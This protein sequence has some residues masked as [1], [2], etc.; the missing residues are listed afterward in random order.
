MYTTR[1][2]ARPGLR[3]HRFNHFITR[4]GN[5]D[6]VFGVE[7][8]LGQIYHA[9]LAVVVGAEIEAL[10]LQIVDAGPE[11]VVGLD[12]AVRIFFAIAGRALGNI[13]IVEDVKRL[14]NRDAVHWVAGQHAGRGGGGRSGGG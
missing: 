3:R 11:R 5:G 14:K 4:H 9:D 6:D 1:R 2:T 7:V 10:A 12:I 13:E 8:H